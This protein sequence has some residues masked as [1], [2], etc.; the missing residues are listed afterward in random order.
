MNE[1]LKEFLSDILVEGKPGESRKYPGY[2]KVPGFGLYSNKPGG[3]VT[4]KVVGGKIMPVKGKETKTKKSTGAP[5]VEKPKKPAVAATPQSAPSVKP[6]SKPADTSDT[7]SSWSSEQV[8]GSLM[9]TTPITLTRGKGTIQ[10]RPI[11][12]P[13]TGKNIETNTDAGRKRA[14]EVINTRLSKLDGPIKTACERLTLRGTEA[15]LQRI[16]KWMGNVGELYT[17]KEML[18][19]GTESY[20][21]PDSYPK[22]DLLVVTKDKDRGLRITEISVKSSTGEE[23]GKLGSNARVPLHAAVEN[24]TINVDGADYEATDA[25]D[26]SM[27]VYS[28]LIRF[29]T[30]G[31]IVGEK[32]VISVKDNKMKNFDKEQIKKAIELSKQGKKSAQELLLQARKITPADLEEFKKSPLFTM[33]KTP[34]QKKLIDYYFNQLSAEVKKNKDFRLGDIRKLFTS[35]LSGILTDTK[36]NLVFESDLVAVKFSAQ[37]GYEGMKITP[38]EVMK[39]RAESKYGDISSMSAEEQLK[40]LGKFRLGTRGLNTH[41]PKTREARNGYAGA[42]I[43]LAPPTELL[44]PEDKLSPKEFVNYIQRPTTPTS[45]VKK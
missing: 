40:K 2:Y 44:K 3:P 32:R 7:A 36:S 42:I 5:S 37:S 35:Q 45:K 31:H 14:L 24:K 21:L 15:Q 27:F 13:D 8:F 26:S 43:N 1:L 25:I 41:H 9:G 22:N 10:V 30:E 20:L 29:G 34:E 4:H 19:A 11:L 38:S 39:S 23:V 16:K 6:V 12:D 28:Q 17:L 18:E 33:T